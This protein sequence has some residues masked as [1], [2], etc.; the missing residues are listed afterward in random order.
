V[1]T[2]S[3]HQEKILDPLTVINQST[4]A[5]DLVKS[6]TYIG[7][8]AI[9]SLAKIYKETWKG[10]SAPVMELALTKGQLGAMEMVWR[11]N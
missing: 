2:K 6:T 7:R 9:G 10:T 11:L 5:L 1:Y 4:E 8:I 3:T